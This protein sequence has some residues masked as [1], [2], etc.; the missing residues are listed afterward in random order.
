MKKHFSRIIIPFFIVAI[1]FG[2][3]GVGKVEA[4]T[5]CRQELN[6]YQNP[7]DGASTADIEAARQAWIACDNKAQAEAKATVAADAARV[8]ELNKPKVGFF[9]W[10]TGAAMDLITGPIAKI[11]MTVNGVLLQAIAIPIMSILFRIAAAMLD[12]SVNFTLSTQIFKDTNLGVVTVWALIRNICNI[13]FIFILLWTAIQMIIGIAGANAKKM[14]ANVI[15]A[16]LLINFSLFITR[17]LIDVGNMLA[18]TLYTNIQNVSINGVSFAGQGLG[19]IIMQ[20]LGMAG[21]TGAA[22]SALSGGFFSVSF[23]MI[24]YLQLI[25]LIVAFIV[26]MYAMLLMATRIVVLIFLAALSPIGFMGSV[27]P[28]LEEYSK[29]W[30][31][32][33]YGQVMIAP[34]FLLF[35]YLI[36]QISSAFN[37][38]PTAGNIAGT[39]D[40]SVAVAVADTAKYLAYFKYVMI[41]MLLIVAVKVTKKMTGAV[42]KAIE[43]FGKMAATAAIGVATG[44]TAFAMRATIGRGANAVATSQTMKDWSVSNNLGARMFAKATMATSGMVSKRSFDARNIPAVSSAAKEHLGVDVKEGA[45]GTKFGSAGKGGYAGRITEQQKAAEERTKLLSEGIDPTKKEIEDKAEAIKLEVVDAKTRAEIL[46]AQNTRTWE[47]EQE[48][49]EKQAKVKKYYGLKKEDL[50][51][52]V[53]GDLITE[54]RIKRIKAEE[55]IEKKSRISKL[56][57]GREERVKKIREAYKKPTKEKVL[58][59]AIAAQAKETATET[60]EEAKPAT[61]AAPATPANPPPTT[62]NPKA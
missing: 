26:F 7:E 11:V 24:S 44:G 57:G 49:K 33:L 51:D 22:S 61:P 45:F 34:I 59:D 30:R 31:E 10:L 48:M 38:V 35:V 32:T 46:K 16:A 5:D 50:E 6:N 52:T 56:M 36:I 25:T 39:T 20:T 47:E 9:D 43:G 21:I 4:Y 40:G 18:A 60:A 1:L 15:I 17:I 14:V 41:I 8:A 42:G 3:F 27:L 29:M 23:G 55:E 12:M 54:K 28:K 58:S 37:S 13:T 53:K 2:V 19:E 62:S